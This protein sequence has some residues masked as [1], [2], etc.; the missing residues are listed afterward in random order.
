MLENLYRRLNEIIIANQLAGLGRLAHILA[1]RLPLWSTSVH[2]A[3]PATSTTLAVTPPLFA[4]SVPA[5][6]FVLKLKVKQ[7]MT[8]QIYFLYVTAPRADIAD[9]IGAALVDEG[10]AACVNI[11]GEMRSIYKWEGKIEREPETPFIVKTN[12]GAVEAARARIVELHPYETPCVAAIAIND[13][14]S[15]LPFLNWVNA[16]SKPVA[17][18]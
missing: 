14:G 15:H 13:A 17:S 3:P 4:A 12:A 5:A 11:H 6:R 7:K 8:G 9:Q 16:N 2:F 18:R 10:L 1:A